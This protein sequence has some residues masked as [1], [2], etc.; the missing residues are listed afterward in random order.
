MI[1]VIEQINAVTRR[2]GN[3]TFNAG[4]ARTVTVG[5]TYDAPVEDVW[6]AL[7][8]PERL[9]RWFLPVTGELRV[10]GRYQ[11][12]GNAGGEIQRCDPPKSFFATWEYG[13]GKSWI[14]VRLTAAPGGRTRLE[15]DHI[16][17]VDDGFREFDGQFGPGAVGLGWDTGLLGLYLHLATGETVDPAKIQEWTLSE[18]GVH[19]FTLSSE[20][21]CKAD[22]ASGTDPDAAR[23]RAATT[24]GFYTTPPEQ[25]QP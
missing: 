4:E 8:N 10:G 9:P 22:I 2:V 7:T 5:R 20:D 25:P 17:P 18:E 12:E 11:L 24:L 14:E 13:E 6:D 23:T 19:F 21:W 15:L 3:S 16:A 1:D